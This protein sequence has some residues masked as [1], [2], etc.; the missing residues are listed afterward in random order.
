MMINIFRIISYILALTQL[1]SCDSIVISKAELNISPTP[2]E[3]KEGGL[4]GYKLSPTATFFIDKNA[5]KGFSEGIARIMA[6]LSGRQDNTAAAVMTSHILERI[7]STHNTQL[8]LVEND[9]DV[10]VRIKAGLSSWVYDKGYTIKVNHR[11]IEI[12]GNGSR[13][14]YNALSTLLQIVNNS[15]IADDSGWAI[16][17][18]EIDDYPASFP[19]RALLIDASRGDLEVEQLK[20][21]IDKLSAYKIDRIHLVVADES[22]ALE[23]NEYPKGINLAQKIYSQD[24][25]IELI[26]FAQW[27]MVNVTLQINTEQMIYGKLAQ[28][29]NTQVSD[30]LKYDFYILENDSVGRQHLVENQGSTYLHT[31][32]SVSTSELRFV[33]TM[34]EEDRTILVRLPNLDSLSDAYI[35]D[36]SNYLWSGRMQ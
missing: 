11:G 18:L 3:V 20:R 35:D 34:N 4:L 32:H 16:P 12:V 9:G 36:L 27:R 19:K 2:N 33:P 1:S 5:D 7:N 8:R 23:L 25:L 15:E 10:S 14:L 29:I 22:W 28:I 17:A 26:R 21:V 30:A 24:E 6:P 13:G 31:P